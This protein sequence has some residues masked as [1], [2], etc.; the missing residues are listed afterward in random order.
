MCISKWSVT[1]TEDSLTPIIKGHPNL[2]CLRTKSLPFALVFPFP[3]TFNSSG[4]TG[5]FW[6][7]EFSVQQLCYLI[8]SVLSTD[9]KE[10]SVVRKVRI[11]FH[12]PC[13]H[14]REGMEQSLFIST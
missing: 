6:T 9:T 3:E 1:A 10:T 13:W 4:G 11:D 14:R 8:C 7:S 5:T 12:I 2:K